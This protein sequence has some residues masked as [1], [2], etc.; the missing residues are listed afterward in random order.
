MLRSAAPYW[1]ET[2]SG[3]QVFNDARAEVRIG[4]AVEVKDSPSAKK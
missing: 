4:E 1:G 3:L 2:T